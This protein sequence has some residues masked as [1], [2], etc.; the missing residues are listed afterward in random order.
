MTRRTP[1]A[2][3]VAVLA[4]ALTWAGS[5]L[6][7]SSE[8]REAL[9]R[10]SKNFSAART[11]AGEFI[12][13]G[14]RGRQTQGK[15]YLARPGRI[16]FDYA[17]PATLQVRS[18]GRT[19]EV[20]NKK[21]KTSDYLPLSRTPLKML[22]ARR[23]NPDDRSIRRVKVEA[24]VTTV[25]LANRKMFGAAKVTLMFDNATS[26]LKQWTITDKQGKDTSVMIFNVQKNPRL[27]KR[28]FKVRKRSRR[29]QN[30]GR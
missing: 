15:F 5:A 4:L 8:E 2:L 22:L 25:V 11:M 1:L 23:I 17:A 26:D 19:V 6:S 30:S 7:R 24:D 12:Q 28:L 16:R 10:I 13:F 18:D 9:S 20:H 27:S 21:L 29:I 14:P 3:F